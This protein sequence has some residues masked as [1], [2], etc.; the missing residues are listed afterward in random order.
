MTYNLCAGASCHRSAQHST[1]CH[2]PQCQTHGTVMLQKTLQISI[3]IMTYKL[4][5]G[6]CWHRSTQENTML[7]TTTPNTWNNDATEYLTDPDMTYD[8]EQ[9]NTHLPNTTPRHHTI[10][11]WTY[12]FYYFAKMPFS[13]VQFLDRLGHL[14]GHEERFNKDPLPFFSSA[15][16]PMSSSGMGRDV[17]SLILSIQL[18]LCLPRCRPPSS[19]CPEGW[20]WRGCQGV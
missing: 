10:N 4:W 11:T 8:L 3:L 12:Y 15:W 19:R 20:F 1:K 18:F 6:I 2:T 14:G 16:G 13:S 17:H 9:D 5:P 7:H